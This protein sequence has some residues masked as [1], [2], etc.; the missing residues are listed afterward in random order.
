MMVLCVRPIRRC[1]GL[2]I[3]PLSHCPGKVMI[4]CSRKISVGL[5]PGRDLTWGGGGGSR[6]DVWTDS[7]LLGG[8]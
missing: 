8:V 7:C 5:G 1:Q 3:Q 6:L 2:D 4:F